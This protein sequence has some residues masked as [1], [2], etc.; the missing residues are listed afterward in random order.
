MY[1]LTMALNRENRE[2]L[3]LWILGMTDKLINCQSTQFH[4]EV[5]ITKCNDEVQ[6]LN[7]DIYNY[8]I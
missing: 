3:W 6:R 5:D 1:E 7:P 8:E 2:F 4:F